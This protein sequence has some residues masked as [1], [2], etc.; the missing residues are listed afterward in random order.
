MNNL[1][2]K[3][4]V[5]DL[6]MYVSLIGGGVSIS[7]Y[8][9]NRNNIQEVFQVLDKNKLMQEERYNNIMSALNKQNQKVENLE[10]MEN[11]NS[12]IHNGLGSV[13]QNFQLILEFLEKKNAEEGINEESQILTDEIIGRLKEIP[14]QMDNVS[15]NFDEYS[16][17]STDLV[18]NNFKVDDFYFYLDNFRENISHLSNEQLF[19]LIHVLFFTALIIATFN[20]AAVFYGDSLIILLDIE[21]RFPKLAKIIKLRRKFQ[22]YYFGLNLIIIFSVLIVLLYFNFFVLFS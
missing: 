20:L 16:K 2:I 5:K 21:N 7:E 12:K 22:Q 1:K 18:K 4:I 17:F 15:N 13:K 8:V 19:S 10:I 9:N 14:N 6:T 3:K 11:L